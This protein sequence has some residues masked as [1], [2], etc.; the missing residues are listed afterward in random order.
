LQKDGDVRTVD[1]LRI[2][3]VGLYYQTLD[4]EESG[5]WNPSSGQFEILD[6]SVRSQI[7]QGIRVARK[8]AP[9][10]LLSLPVNSPVVSL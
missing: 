9:A 2:G 1:F 5:R 7:M 6:D 3:R 4:A 10:E 8:Q